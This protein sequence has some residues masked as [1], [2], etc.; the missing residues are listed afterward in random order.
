MKIYAFKNTKQK[1]YKSLAM[2]LACIEQR[3]KEA[4]LKEYFGMCKM[5]YRIISV[6]VYTWDNQEEGEDDI[7][8]VF[9]N[10]MELYTQN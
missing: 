2:K 1:K 6:V 10:V 7:E 9:K 5:I 8:E 3:H 4:I